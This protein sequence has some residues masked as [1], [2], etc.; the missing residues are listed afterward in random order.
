MATP[1]DVVTPPQRDHLIE[2][3][4]NL[5]AALEAMD[6]SAEVAGYI[7]NAKTELAAESEPVAAEVQTDQSQIQQ[8]ATA[9]GGPTP[10]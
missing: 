4:R 1:S 3:V 7:A 5:I 10:Q 9:D 2:A 6:H 8:A